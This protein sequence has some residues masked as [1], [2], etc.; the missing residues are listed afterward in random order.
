MH[1]FLPKPLIA[2]Q[3]VHGAT[4]KWTND[5]S[6]II[7]NQTNQLYFIY[8][9]HPNSLQVENGISQSQSGHLE[10]VAGSDGPSI[11]VTGSYA[12]LGPNNEQLIL[13][14]I[15][16]ALGYRATGPQVPVAPPTL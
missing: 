14:Y 6:E 3:M 4:R 8:F 16:D 9:L 12:Q 7:E 2:A 5:S 1:V 11:S 13:N 10:Q 15:A